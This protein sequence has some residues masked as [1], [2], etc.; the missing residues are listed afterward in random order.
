MDFKVLFD[1]RFPI[2][3]VWLLFFAVC[4]S[5]SI[6]IPLKTDYRA[7]FSKEDPYFLNDQQLLDTYV[8]NDNVLFVLSPANGQALSSESLQL[9]IDMTDAAWQLP[10]SVR[11]DSLVN[12]QHI[13]SA[14]DELTV[15]DLIEDLQGYDGQRLVELRKVIR[16]DTELLGRLLAYDERV[17]AI[18]VS[19]RFP[20]ESLTETMDVANASRALAQQFRSL[21][22]GTEIYIT[23]MVMGNNAPIEVILND[24]QTLVP[25]MCLCIVVLLTLLFRSLYSTILTMI[26]VFISVFSTMGLWG[27]VGAILSGPSASAPIII[28]TIAVADCV[29]ILASFFNAYRKGSQKRDAIIESLRL[30]VMPV[31]LTSLTTAIGFLTMNFSDVP[32]FNILGN[33]VAVGVLIACLASLSLLPILIDLFPLKEKRA[34]KDDTTLLTPFAEF[35]LRHRFLVFVVTAALSIVIASFSSENEINDQFGKFYSKN[36]DFR[37][38]TDFANEHLSSFYSIDISLQSPY[39]RGIY[40]QRYLQRVDEFEIWIKTLPEV[41][42]TQ[43]IATT[44]KGLNKAMHDNDESWYVLPEGGDLAAQYFL[45]YEMSLPFGLDANQTVSFDKRESKINVTLKEMSTKEILEFE[46]LVAQWLSEN[47]AEYDYYHS[48]L[49]LLF[50]HLGMNN[51]TSMLFGT[52]VALLLMSLVIGIALKSVR[53]GLVSLMTNVIPALLAFGVWGIFSGE[54]G[55]SISISIGMTL[56]IVV[57]NTVHLLSKYQKSIQSGEN[58]SDAILFSFSHVGVALLICNCVL[59]AGFMILAQSDFQLNAHM[60]LFTSLTFALALLV[61]FLL[62]PPVLYWLDSKREVKGEGSTAEVWNPRA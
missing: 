49:A 35:V 12:F 27:W 62:L 45:L 11:V 47:A 20:G 3:G 14:E 50:S 31:I 18:S 23:G 37:T 6:Y 33:A 4:V 29:H 36:I 52:M 28:L 54:V 22:P 34:I 19:F 5:G 1:H 44:F 32:P 25:L 9:Q 60:G 59:I 40:D 46:N 41:I 21:Y 55:L 61:D 17:S 30:N 56:G 26:I 2:L 58:T 10:F 16:D 38:S 43:T 53:L 57:D 42:Q 51:A 24:A 15:K 48:S 39:E 7:F 13:S 8:P